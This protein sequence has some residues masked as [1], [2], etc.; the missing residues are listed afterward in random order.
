MNYAGI[1]LSLVL[2]LLAGCA[3]MDPTKPLAAAMGGAGIRVISGSWPGGWELGIRFR[4]ASGNPTTM[5]NGGI[6]DS[7]SDDYIGLP[8]PINGDRLPLFHQ[9]DIRLDKKFVFKKWILSIYLDIQNVYNY[10]ASEFV[11]YN[12]NY[13]QKGYLNGLLGYTQ[14]PHAS[15]DFNTDPHSGILDATQTR[16]SGHTMIKLICWFDN[17]WGYSM[18]TADLAAMMAKSL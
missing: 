1:G 11:I 2:L 10:Q 12:F 3:E 17:E 13:T 16:V 18:R 15:V 5:F 6:F 7:D 8:G 14:E 9:L 4:L